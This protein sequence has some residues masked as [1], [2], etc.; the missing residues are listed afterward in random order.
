[1]NT[2]TATVLVG[3]Q[4]ARTLGVPTANLYVPDALLL[5]GPGVYAGATTTEDSVDSV[6][7]KYESCIFLDTKGTLESHLIGVKDINLYG[8]QITVEIKHKIR[9]ML[10]FT[11][12]GMDQIKDQLMQDVRDC[13][14]NVI[15]SNV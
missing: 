1:M 6:V 7:E 4:V 11:G 9:D 15:S 14:F 13:E 5:H 8:K 3:T 2:Y 12:W 10:D